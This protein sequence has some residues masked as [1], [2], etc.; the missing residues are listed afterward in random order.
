MRYSH[1]SAGAILRGDLGTTEPSRTA[2][3]EQIRAGTDTDR[4]MALACLVAGDRHHHLAAEILPDLRA[5]K[6]VV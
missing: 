6:V 1:L 3:G 4:G 2:L 5:G